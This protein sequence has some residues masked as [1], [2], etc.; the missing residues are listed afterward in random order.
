MLVLLDRDGVI[1]HDSPTGITSVDG[2]RIIEGSAEAIA[3]LN[4]AQIKLAVVTNQSVVGKGLITREELDAIHEKLKQMLQS[5][6]AHLDGLYVCT[7]H[8]NQPTHRR[9]PEPGMLLEALGEFSAS[10]AETPMVGDALRDLQAACSAGCIPHLVRTGKGAQ[11][12]Q[13][14]GFKVL[15]EIAVH[16]NLAAFADQL[17]G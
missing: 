1:N 16:D 14:E 3:R 17:L 5:V 6:G 8:P 15:G 12:E 4:A 13:N 11:T 9:K 2:L 10:P 7:D